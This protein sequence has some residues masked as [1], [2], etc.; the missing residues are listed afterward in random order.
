LKTFFSP[1]Y[2]LFDQ[3][4]WKLTIVVGLVV[5]G[6]AYRALLDKLWVL[7]GGLETVGQ[8]AQ[9]QTI[10]DL[11]AAPAFLGVGVGLTVLIAQRRASERTAL[12]MASYV[13]GMAFTLPAIIAILVFSAEIA[14]WMQLENQFQKKLILSASLGWLF[15][16]TS[17]LNS[18]W[19]GREQRGRVLLFTIAVST[20][21]LL[22]LGY[23]SIFNLNNLMEIFLVCNIIISL[24]CNIALIRYL[25]IWHRSSTESI[26]QFKLACKRLIRYLPAGFSIGL[27][28]PLSG[29][30]IRSTIAQNMDWEAVGTAT[31]I[32]RASDWVLSIAQSV[33]Y[34]Y[35]LPKIS[36]EVSSQNLMYSMRNM[37]VKI[38]IP[39]FIALLL[40]LIF[41]NPILH[42]LYGDQLEAP[43]EITALFWLGD[44][45][46]IVAAVFLM[47]LYTLH[48]S[49]AIAIG[50]LLSQPLFALLLFISIHLSLVDIGKYHLLTYLIYSI[51]CIGAWV[52]I[53]RNSKMG[54]NK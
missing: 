50:E 2:A 20:P 15:I 3:G 19:L 44:F 51:F 21:G 30:A 37:A 10:S 1:F 4:L 23:G 7:Y 45:L 29:L 26:K 22:I 34:F 28:T 32:W 18:Y 9:L 43:R 27:L 6:P 35:F 40:L 5:W 52:Y 12:L 38:L 31:A 54:I 49:K 42:V 46:R 13:L 47:G 11:V 25:W 8:W 53:A 41:Q 48:A 17:Q 39:S 16:I 33:L 14:Q 36:K 24:A